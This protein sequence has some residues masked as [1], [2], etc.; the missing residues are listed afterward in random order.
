MEGRGFWFGPSEQDAPRTAWRETRQLLS[1]G[2]RAP[3]LG[4]QNRI[5]SIINPFV[6]NGSELEVLDHGK[7]PA[8]NAI[9]RAFRKHPGANHSRIKA[10]TETKSYT[11]RKTAKRLPSARGEAV[12][13]DIVTEEEFPARDVLKRV[14]KRESD[15][16]RHR[17]L[18]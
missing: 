13:P 10:R 4:L 18:P 6:F 8:A 1:R 11:A 12:S 17:V 7:N 14:I 3:V 5:S 15:A 2:R 16:S 9:F